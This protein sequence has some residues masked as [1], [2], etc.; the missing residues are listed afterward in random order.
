MQPRSSPFTVKVTKHARFSTNFGGTS[1]AGTAGRGSS[2]V[3]RTS[4]V[5]ARSSKNFL[6]DGV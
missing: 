2:A 1:L 5:R 3:A 6:S 4:V